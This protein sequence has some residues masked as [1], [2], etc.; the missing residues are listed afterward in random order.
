[1]AMAMETKSDSFTPQSPQK[2]IAS[3]IAT[4]RRAE[5]RLDEL[6]SAR[7]GRAGE[8]LAMLPKVTGPVAPGDD[9]LEIER[10]LSDAFEYAPI[11]VAFVSP[12]GR[13]WLKVNRALC[14]LLGYTEEEFLV[15]TTGDF[16]HPDD[17]ESSIENIRKA[18]SGRAQSVQLEKRYLHRNGHVIDAALSI[19]LV[20]DASGNPLHFIGHIQDI[21]ERKRAE[22]E[23]RESNQKFHQLANHITDAFWIRSPDMLSVQY[24]SPAFEKIWGRPVEYLYT[25]PHE[26]TNFIV[27]EDRQRVFATFSELTG[28]RE[29]LDLEYRIMRPGGEVRW[30]RSRGYQV[31]DEE[32]K[33]TRNIGI[34]TDITDRMLSEISLRESQKRLRD[35]IDG[36]GPAMFVGLLTP[37]GI[38][39]EINRSSLNAVGVEAVE[40]LGM[41][42][43]E[44]PWWAELP[45]VKLQVRDAIERAAAG[46]ASRFDLT[47]HGAEGE[48]IELDFSLQPLRDESGRVVCLVP[49]ASVI[50]ERKQAEEELRRAQKMDAVGQL[51]AG[52]AHEFNNIL[53]TLLSMATISRLNGASPETVRIASAMEVQIRRGATLTQQL[54]LSARPEAPTKT[55]LDLREQ[56]THARDLLQRLVP[57]NIQL[58]LETS[59]QPAVVDGDAGQIQQVLLN[60]AI[61]ARD[62]MP[63]G[64]IL[65]LRVACSR[66]EV[67]LEVEDDGVG[68]D[69]TTREHLFEPF[70]TTKRV[71]EGTGLGLAVVYRIVEQHGGHIEVRSTPGEG[72]L[73]RVILPPSSR[74]PERCP[75]AGASGIPRGSGL[76]LL[77]E[78]EEGVREGITMLLNMFGYEVIAAGRGEEALELPLE[79]VPDLLLSDVSLP[80]IGGPVLAGQLRTR[81]PSMKVVLM[82]GYLEEGTRALA[83]EK[84]W[85]VLQKP[86]EVDDLSRHIAEAM[87]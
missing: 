59:E 82:T 15:S 45:E 75:D 72:S 56:I 80:G 2:E 19:A 11:G 3:L 71:G 10:R 63:D 16:T 55:S 46:E 18:L 79:P 39:V 70:F 22:N 32:G 7:G 74:S 60:L 4:I 14:D 35:L 66:N 12:D 25:H 26:W 53:Q 67:A 20:R 73:F 8:G 23:L 44:A 77:V 64:G 65:T 62:A 13:R 85:D 41:P 27:P 36:L 61:N 52:V 5:Q 47:A 78:D 40:V 31:R 51:A 58:D 49:S 6:T 34:V 57:E 50:T 68:F 33:L 48:I 54:L 24:V 86:F 43:A 9:T 87:G 37:E 81:W 38:L 1:M 83:R 21:T 76:I 28:E 69:E 42:F 30:I 84:G 17:I 29:E